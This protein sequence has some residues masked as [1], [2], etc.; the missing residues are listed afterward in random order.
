MVR[1]PLKEYFP[2]IPMTLACQVYGAK[3]GHDCKTPSKVRLY[4]VHLARVK[5][6]AEM[7]PRLSLNHR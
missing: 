1:S 5:A 3:L 6:A 4:V 2:I 7:E